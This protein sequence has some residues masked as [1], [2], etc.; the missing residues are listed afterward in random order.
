MVKNINAASI[1]HTLCC[2]P[3]SIALEGFVSLPQTGSFS[4]KEITD[5]KKTGGKGGGVSLKFV[6]PSLRF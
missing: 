5:F 6:K 1:F 2:L 3:K 4:E